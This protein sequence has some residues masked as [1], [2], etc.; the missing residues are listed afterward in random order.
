MLNHQLYRV[1]NKGVRNDG[2]LNLDSKSFFGIKILL[3]GLEEQK[4]VADVLKSG[5]KEIQKMEAKLEVLQ[6]QKKGLM[7][8]LL[9]G[10]T[11][12][13]HLLPEE[14]EKEKVVV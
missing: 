6:D 13:T 3:P 11:R 1:I 14:S 9:T 12:V 4:K 5:E 10:K 7:Q 2:L 8:Q